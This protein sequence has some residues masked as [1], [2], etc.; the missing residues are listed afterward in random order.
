MAELN[1]VVLPSHSWSN[2][3]GFACQFLS[4]SMWH[5]RSFAG[6]NGKEIDHAECLPSS[7]VPT[8]CPQDPCWSHLC[9]ASHIKRHS[10]LQPHRPHQETP[11]CD[12]PLDTGRAILT[13]GMNKCTHKSVVHGLEDRVV[14]SFLRRYEQ[15]Y[16]NPGEVV[17]DRLKLTIK[18]V[19]WI[20]TWWSNKHTYELSM[21]HRLREDLYYQ[22]VHFS[23]SDDSWKLNPWSL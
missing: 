5:R 3:P 2:L 20:W 1:T 16:I 4:A 15:T 11:L 17:S 9:V 10:P 12:C 19:Q 6:L 22:K 8:C 14:R 23:M 13:L 7:L 18:W 21:I